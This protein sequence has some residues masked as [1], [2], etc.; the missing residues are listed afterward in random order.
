MSGIGYQS[1]VYR[2]VQ[3]NSAHQ[4]TGK[5]RKHKI[6]ILMSSFFQ[7]GRSYKTAKPVDNEIN[8]A[9]DRNHSGVTDMAATHDEKH[10]RCAYEVFFSA[11]LKIV[12]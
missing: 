4:E 7:P 11:L 12:V 3:E 1:A 6:E 9:A 8:D 5:D 2:R 10:C